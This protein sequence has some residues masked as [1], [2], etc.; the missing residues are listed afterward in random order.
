[1]K[2]P[3]VICIIAYLLPSPAQSLTKDAAIKICQNAAQ[4]VKE[5]KTV[6]E[7]ENARSF[8]NTLETKLLGLAEKIKATDDSQQIVKFR[9]QCIDGIKTSEWI[10]ELYKKQ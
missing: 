10:R 9:R 6:M 4:K 5:D 7:S 3:L 1:M 8:F 2:S